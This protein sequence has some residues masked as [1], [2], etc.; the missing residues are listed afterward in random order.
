MFESGW[1]WNMGG[2]LPGFYGGDNDQIATT[3]SG[4]QHASGCWS[5]RLM[6]RE[7]GAG[8]VYTYLPPGYAANDVQCNV[9]PFSTCNPTYGASVG[10]GAFH[11]QPGQW[12]TVSQRVRLND[13]GQANGEIELFV[14]G[15][16][17]INV[18]GLVLCDSA[19]GRFRGIQIQTF[20]GGSTAAWAS[21]QYQTA[22][23]SDFSVAI[24][25][26]F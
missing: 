25:E 15:Q 5:A 6:W 17:T 2:K 10:R 21:P 22:Y 4:G 18:S 13:P 20:F 9:P 24:I 7:E 11:F 8:E 14:D 19:A 16:S 23:F 12:T 3:C 1:Q 26:T